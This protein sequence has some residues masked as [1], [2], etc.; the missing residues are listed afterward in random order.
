MSKLNLVFSVPH[1]YNKGQWSEIIS[2]ICN[3][4]NNLSEGK[5]TARYYTATVAPAVT[6]MPG[7]K[8]DQVWDS[9]P[10]VTGSV[11]PGVAASYVRLGWICVASGNPGTWKEIRTLT[12]A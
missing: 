5:I 2:A 3:Q 8:G 12:G 10:T 11:A 6:A 1:E 4:V 7:T 9:N